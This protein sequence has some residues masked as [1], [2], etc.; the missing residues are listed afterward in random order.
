MTAAKKAKSMGMKYLKQAVDMGWA[1]STLVDMH[2]NKP[3]R[4]E[5]VILGCLAK[6]DI[7]FHEQMRKSVK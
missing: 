2:N 6:Q 3:E 7:L 1:R 5:I 4:F